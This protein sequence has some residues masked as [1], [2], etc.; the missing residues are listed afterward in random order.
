MVMLML[1]VD[2]PANLCIVVV[3][4]VL[5]MVMVNMMVMMIDDRSVQ[6]VLQDCNAVTFLPLFTSVHNCTEVTFE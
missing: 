5:I 6:I 1:M 3:M 4:V 2:Q